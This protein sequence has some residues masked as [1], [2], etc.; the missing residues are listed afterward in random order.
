MLRKNKDF[1][2]KNGYS[3]FNVS[4]SFIEYKCEILQVK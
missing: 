3:F 4:D 1:D 2:F